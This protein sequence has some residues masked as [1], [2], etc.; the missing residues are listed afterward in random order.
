MR[1]QIDGLG[2]AIVDQAQPTAFVE[3][4]PRQL[5]QSA[6]SLVD[7]PAI[8]ALARCQLLGGHMSRQALGVGL[9]VFRWVHASLG[10]H[11]RAGCT[12]GPEPAAAQRHWFVFTLHRSHKCC[13]RPASEANRKTGWPANNP[14][15][16]I[17]STASGNPADAL[18]VA[19]RVGLLRQTRRWGGM[20]SW[21]RDRGN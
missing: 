5:G 8:G 9:G 15:Q 17:T 21:Q 18:V 7:M 11:T 3:I 19:R 10:P 20:H 6:V 13:P 4:K 1:M 14:H 2:H 16:T 12:E